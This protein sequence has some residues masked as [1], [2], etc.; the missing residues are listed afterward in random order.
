MDKKHISTAANGNLKSYIVGF[1][2]SV[3]LTLAAYFVVASHLFAGWVLLLIITVL[4]VEQLVV[5]LSFFLHLGRESKPRWNLTAFISMLGVIFIVVFGSVW[6]MNNLNYNM[7]PKH[8]M[9]DYMKTE[10]NKGF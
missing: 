5:Q 8:Q 6:I 9:D 10:S 4:A 2:L 3:I 1:V 7:M